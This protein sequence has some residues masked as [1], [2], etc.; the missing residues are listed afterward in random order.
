MRKRTGMCGQ[1]TTCNIIGG[2]NGGGHAHSLWA[3]HRPC[4]FLGL[5]R[6]GVVR[7][8]DARPVFPSSVTRPIA[9]FHVAQCVDL[10][11]RGVARICCRGTCVNKIA[12]CVAQLRTRPR[13]EPH[14]ELL[15]VR[16]GVPQIRGDD[17]ASA[18]LQH[19]SSSADDSGEDDFT[20]ASAVLPE[21][22]W[23]TSNNPIIHI[24]DKGKGALPR[25]RQYGGGD[26]GGGGENDV[27]ALLHLVLRQRVVQISF[28]HHRTIFHPV[29]QEVELGEA[30]C[31]RVD[32]DH[33]RSLGV[34]T[35][36]GDGLDPAPRPKVEHGLGGA[37]GRVG[38]E[39]LARRRGV[40]D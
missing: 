11:A 13:F 33:H 29:E 24:S 28:P 15:V 3:A 39:A 36:S 35:Q 10:N 30:H 21:R 8:R 27:E 37:D 17:E 23:A 26:G 4:E 14:R 1:R 18:V 25:V 20:A 19:I 5:H 38:D 12:I 22:C 31:A 16:E 2:G 34:V 7:E 32:V 9:H 40:A 6:R